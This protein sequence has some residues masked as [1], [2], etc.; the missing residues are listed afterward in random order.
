MRFFSVVLMLL[1]APAWADTASERIHDKAFEDAR[2]MIYAHDIDGFRAAVIAAHA[3]DLAARGAQDLQRAWFG[4]F[5]VT[6]PRVAAF[7]A[8]WLAAEPDSPYALTARV[9]YLRAMGWA[10]R[11]N[12]LPRFT[13][14]QA[15]DEM[16]EMHGEAMEMALRAST[17]APDMVAASDAVI[18]MGQ[19]FGMADMAKAELARIMAI[20]PNH[21]SLLRAANSLSPKWGGSV[22]A[23]AQACEDYATLL[24]DVEG[25]TGDICLVE[26]FVAAPVDGPPRTWAWDMLT[27]LPDHPNL[28]EARMQKAVA[29]EGSHPERLA[30]LEGYFASGGMWTTAAWH[31]DIERSAS[32]RPFDEAYP[33]AAARAL[34]DTTDKLLHDAGDPDLVKRYFELIEQ[35][36]PNDLPDV[37]AQMA[38]LRNLLAIAPYNAKGWAKLADLQS[39]GWSSEQVRAATPA[40][41]N[42]VVYSNHKTD[43]IREVMEIYVSGYLTG[44]ASARSAAISNESYVYPAEFDVVV[45]CPY[46]RL[47][48]VLAYRCEAEGVDWR[49]C[50][51]SLATFPEM[52]AD[53]DE[54][55]ARGACE[56]ER[57]AD[58]ESL[59]F[60]PA[61]GP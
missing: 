6:D 54:I 4:P 57:T 9:W 8:D 30:A 60:E 22:A 29:N 50:G 1:M 44:T 35:S 28:I 20:A 36:V 33:A 7:T 11:G 32:G 5:G 40:V 55:A 34:A 61:G 41:A 19:T 2:A 38:V 31:L 46:T 37:A 48:R 59:T 23:V 42:A 27:R 52:K 26:M 13:W 49:E 3:A 45:A 17:L 43:I 25:Y 12:D 14:Y 53:V 24:P 47:L 51:T 15:M 21:G 18:R 10:M 56:A 16:A 58:I 39:R